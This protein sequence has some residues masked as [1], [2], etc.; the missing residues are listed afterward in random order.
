M[1]YLLYCSFVER[2]NLFQSEIQKKLIIKLNRIELAIIV[3]VT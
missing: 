3:Y 1:Y 2:Y